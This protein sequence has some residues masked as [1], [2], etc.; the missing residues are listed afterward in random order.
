MI[1]LKG[2]TIIE[3]GKHWNTSGE[4]QGLVAGLLP[5]P[6]RTL[7]GASAAAKGPVPPCRMV[8]VED[9]AIRGNLCD[10]K[11]LDGS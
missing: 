10:T 9:V 7:V 8:S 3:C 4:L 2:Q 1:H 5:R 11:S 6:I